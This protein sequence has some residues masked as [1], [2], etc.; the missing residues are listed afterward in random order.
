M[1]REEYNG[2]R[3]GDVVRVR[4]SGKLYLAG[5]V[6]TAAEQRARIAKTV[7]EHGTSWGQV[8]RE[9]DETDVTFVQLRGDVREDK[10]FGALRR[11][12]PAAIDLDV[13]ATAAYVRAAVPRI[14][15]DVAAAEAEQGTTDSADYVRRSAVGM[16]RYAERMAAR[17]A[18]M[19]GQ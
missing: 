6:E 11:L 8:P 3:V 19:E 17:L 4:R 15:A 9:G 5:W 12:N 13:E 18:E 2:L 7:A 14:W 1:T 10:R 16:R